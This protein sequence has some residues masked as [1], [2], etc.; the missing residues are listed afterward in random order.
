MA[1]AIV[2]SALRWDAVIRTDGDVSLRG[3]RFPFLASNATT[4]L[5]TMVASVELSDTVTMMADVAK[6][7]A[8]TPS[9][10]RPVR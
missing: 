10:P 7:A 5:K 1:R 8:T 9:T 3:P 6:E 4:S 2:P